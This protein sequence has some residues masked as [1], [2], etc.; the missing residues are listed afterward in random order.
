ML[1]M[2]Q[3]YIQWRNGFDMKKKTERAKSGT[4]VF[5]LLFGLVFIVTP[6]R[7]Q[8][9]SFRPFDE[10]EN[11]YRHIYTILSSKLIFDR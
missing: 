8:A 4:T 7:A 1:R 3:V 5:F 9:D 11:Y 6:T 2:N 10:E